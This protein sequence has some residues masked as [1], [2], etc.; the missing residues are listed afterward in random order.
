MTV[1]AQTR[2]RNS[3]R[4]TLA[5]AAISALILALFYVASPALAGE[6]GPDVDPEDTHEFGNHCPEAFPERKF[7]SKAAR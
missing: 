4:L 5:L 1:Q 7:A 3:A 2:T 6:E